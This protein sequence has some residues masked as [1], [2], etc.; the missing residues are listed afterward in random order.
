MI[1]LLMTLAIAGILWPLDAENR[2]LGFG[3]EPLSADSAARYAGMAYHELRT[4]CDDR[5]ELCLTVTQA[6]A[7]MA[8]GIGDRLQSIDFSNTGSTVA[9]KQVDPDS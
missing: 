6:A 5:A 2:P 8:Y 9:D 3:G 4:F 1:R 7:G